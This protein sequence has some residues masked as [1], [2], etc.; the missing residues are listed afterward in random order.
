MYLG[1]MATDTQMKSYMCT[2]TTALFVI[3]E[4]WKLSKCPLPD[5]RVNE[6]QSIPRLE[7]CLMV[8]SNGVLTHATALMDLERV[9][10]SEGSQSKDSILHGCM[11][12][13]CPEQTNL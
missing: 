5:E 2:F 12:M 11:D 13:K 7:Y 6:M 10:P 3:A 8:K 9:K 4:N 1:E